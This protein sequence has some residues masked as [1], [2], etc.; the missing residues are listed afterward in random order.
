MIW[1]QF[2]PTVWPSYDHLSWLSEDLEEDM[3]NISQTAPVPMTATEPPAYIRFIHIVFIYLMSK[4]HQ[5][6][7]KYCLFIIHPNILYSGFKDKS[8]ILNSCY[9]LIRNL[10]VLDNPK[11]GGYDPQ[12][13]HSLSAS[14]HNGEDP[15][16]PRQDSFHMWSQKNDISISCAP[17]ASGSPAECWS[18]SG[19]GCCSPHSR[20]CQD[21]TSC[22][23]GR[24]VPSSARPHCPHR[25]PST[26]PEPGHT[27]SS[28]CETAERRPQ[29]GRR[30]W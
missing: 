19:G 28:P 20:R 30:K 2:W 7:G 13:F 22:T 11:K 29:F 9:L 3:F 27:A 17:K 24:T 16:E 23:A 5:M 4:S 26:F 12:S 15:K 1:C 8:K 14:Q 25:P 6:Q 21:R 18:G 10:A